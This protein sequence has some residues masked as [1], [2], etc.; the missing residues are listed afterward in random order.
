MTENNDDTDEKNRT[1]KLT[2]INEKN[3]TIH[4]QNIRPIFNSIHFQNLHDFKQGR[5]SVMNK[6][7]I[8]NNTIRSQTLRPT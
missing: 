2:V 4:E 1:V 7:T 5:Q 6:Q 3:E 8:G